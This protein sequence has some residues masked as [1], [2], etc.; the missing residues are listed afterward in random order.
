VFAANGRIDAAE[1]ELEQAVREPESS[2]NG[3]IPTAYWSACK[4]IRK[5]KPGLRDFCRA[6]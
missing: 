3:S 6:L 5:G 2:I 4:S 1:A